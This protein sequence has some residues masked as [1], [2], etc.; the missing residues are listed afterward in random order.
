MNTYWQTSSIRGT[1]E[2]EPPINSSYIGENPR[3]LSDSGF[4]PDFYGDKSGIYCI[5]F[6]MK[7]NGK[8]K[9]TPVHPVR[10]WSSSVFILSGR[11][12]SAWYTIPQT[13]HLLK[14]SMLL[15]HPLQFYSVLRHGSYNCTPKFEM[16][17]NLQVT[18]SLPDPVP[19][20]N[21]IRSRHQID[22]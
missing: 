18:A 4:I 8:G 1:W 2:T 20:Q 14:R 22:H 5:Y 10:S 6:D 9:P 12:A 17:D 19:S 11:S 16:C 21:Q 3:E 7:L 13:F 15:E